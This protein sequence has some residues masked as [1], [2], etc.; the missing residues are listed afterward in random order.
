MAFEA[1]KAEF[2]LELLRERLEQSWRARAGEVLRRHGHRITPAERTSYATRL[3]SATGAELL[4]LRRRLLDRLLRG[5]GLRRRSRHDWKGQADLEMRPR[6]PYNDRAVLEAALRLA[7]A[8]D[9]LW[10]REFLDLY[11][12]MEKLRAAC[13]VGG[14]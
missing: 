2:P 14:P 3:R 12:G 8:S 7:A 9:A 13:R 4:P 1:V 5:A 10:T 11:A 6:G